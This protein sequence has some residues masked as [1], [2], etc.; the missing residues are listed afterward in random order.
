MSSVVDS[1]AEF[2]G[3]IKL[4]QVQCKLGI[5]LNINFKIIYDFSKV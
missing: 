1:Q 4:I 5:Q 3:V 2:Y